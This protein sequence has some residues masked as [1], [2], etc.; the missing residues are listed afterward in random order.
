MT[1]LHEIDNNINI[2][3]EETNNNKNIQSNDENQDGESFHI[4]EDKNEIFT[5]KIKWLRIVGEWIIF[6]QCFSALYNVSQNS[7]E[8]MILIKKDSYSNNDYNDFFLTIIQK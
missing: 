2:Q 6:L 1:E 4:T 5:P 7:K 3:V 8:R